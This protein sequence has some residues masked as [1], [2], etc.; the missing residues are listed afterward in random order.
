MKHK[1]FID[2]EFWIF[3]L[4]NTLYPKSAN[5]FA[6][7]EK[8]MTTY[9]MNELNVG[10]KKANFL[11]DYYWKNYGTT[12]SGM[13]KEHKINPEPYLNEVHNIPLNS[14][15]VDLVLVSEINKLKGKK[16]VYT[17]GSKFHANRVLTARGLNNCFQQIFGIED[18][19]YIPKP[20]EDAYKKILKLGN[21]NPVKAVMFED[22]PKNLE[23]PD[24]LGMQTVLITDEAVLD[25][26]HHI[27]NNLTNFLSNLNISL[28][29]N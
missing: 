28:N 12:L 23:V 9:V 26:R 17:N 16:I 3:E 24:K 22:E 25:A 6:E 20:E 27:T 21:I 10:F 14:L 19:N 1:S 8:K 5:L 15:N 2:V 11:R 29:G 4:D 7:I 13:M 18:A